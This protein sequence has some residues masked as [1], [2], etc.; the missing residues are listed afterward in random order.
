MSSIAIIG[1]AVTVFI[2]A[3]LLFYQS[4]AAEAFANA[5]VKNLQNAWA[6]WSPQLPPIAGRLYDPASPANETYPGLADL[7]KAPVTVP[8]GS[9]QL[10]QQRS[11]GTPGTR[12]T[13]RT[14]LAQQKDLAELASKITLWLEAAGQRESERPGS[15]TGEQMQRR[16][17]LQGRRADL[18]TQMETGM[19]TD[20][21]ATVASEL[22]DLRK[23]VVGWQEISPSLEDVY[24]FGVGKNPNAFL[25]HEEYV[26][27]YQLFSTAVQELEGLT[28]PDPL[29]KVRLQQLQVMR[30]DLI[31]NS[32][33]LGTPPIKMSAAKLYLR[34]MLKAD[35]PLPT[36]Y[37]ME[38]P[39]METTD[40]DNPI[41]VIADLR[42]IQWN[43]T[44]SYDPGAQ[45]MK[46]AT[47]ALLDR[48]QTGEISAQEARQ[49][50][51][52]MRTRPSDSPMMPSPMMSSPGMP[53]SMMPSSMM[54][55]S[56]GRPGRYD[57]KP[58]R[59]DDRRLIERANLLCQQITEAFP[60]D[61]QALGCRYDIESDYDAETVIN[62]VCDRLRY[63]A[64]MVTPEQFGC[65]KRTV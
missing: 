6:G 64:P 1:A 61:A 52:G 58:A 49:T 18:N 34:Q 10:S 8:P 16:V 62:T 29:Q 27:F 54:A 35:Q 12:S 33:L 11:E 25:T 45:E 57:P 42:D 55:G 50:V 24:K 47:A 46:R 40:E 14:A 28:Q 41:D 63:S 19:I 32:K 37:S 44:V 9:I 51:V 56:D 20:S 13:P 5:E 3:A 4:N 7:S 22:M 23:E 59:K 39:P 21:Y 2:V 60:E 65:P 48:L 36:L 15:L 26:R 38:P 43:L 30:Q 17:I 31:T 53:S